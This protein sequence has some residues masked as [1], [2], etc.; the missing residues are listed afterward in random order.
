MGIAPAPSGRRAAVRRRPAA[1]KKFAQQMAD[2]RG[3]MKKE[4]PRTR[5]PHDAPYLLPLA[6]AV[7]MH[8]AFPAR[9]L[10]VG[11]RAMVEPLPRIAQKLRATATQLAVA[12]L[13]PAV[14]PYHQLNHPLFSLNAA[15]HHI[16]LQCKN[17][18]NARMRAKI[19]EN[20]Q[21]VAPVCQTPL[22]LAA[23]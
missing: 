17:P 13:V 19:V 14:Q 10:G 2:G 11:K 23:I 1:G 22:T 15:L 12:L 8:A 6:A 5:P 20:P 4:H 21:R 18:R 16:C 9:R 7:A 3:G